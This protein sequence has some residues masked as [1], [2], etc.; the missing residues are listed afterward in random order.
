[1]TQL[2]ATFSY[3][4]SIGEREASALADISDVYGIWKL[5]LDEQDRSI[6]VEYDATRLKEDDI[7]FMLRNAGFHLAPPIRKAA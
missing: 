5:K 2:Q 3:S 4:N 6:Q 7:A 1:M